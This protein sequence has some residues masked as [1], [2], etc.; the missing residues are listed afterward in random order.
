MAAIAYLVTDKDGKKHQGR[1]DSPGV[2]VSAL[3]RIVVETHGVRP[4]DVIA[5]TL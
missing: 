1:L 5:T 3:K 2:P 4:R